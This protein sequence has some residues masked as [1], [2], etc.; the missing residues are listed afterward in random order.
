MIK[1]PLQSGCTESIKLKV[2]DYRK[3]FMHPSHAPK[4]AALEAIQSL[5][6]K[7]QGG[8]KVDDYCGGARWQSVL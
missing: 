7:F 8:V 4:G 1:L 5:R 6:R 3:Q 2:S